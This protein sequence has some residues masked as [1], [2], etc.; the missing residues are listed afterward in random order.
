M[1]ETRINHAVLHLLNEMFDG[2]VPHQ[3][4]VLNTGDPG[5]LASL[6]KLTSEQASAT[7]AGGASI[8]AHMEHVRYG[9][10]LA[11]RWSRGENPYA[12]A[13]FAA[14]WQQNVVSEHEWAERRHA[15][16]AEAVAWREA[17]QQPRELTG[18]E[19][20]GVIATAVHLAYHLGAVRQIDRSI[21]GPAAND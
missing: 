4:F 5:L 16:R 20:N 7:P 8:A 12:D 13:N 11:N 2:P 14:S 3:A 9:L 1:P 10:E 6:D 15:L 19:L 18:I 21:R 17:L